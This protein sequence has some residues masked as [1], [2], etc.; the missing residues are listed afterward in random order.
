MTARKPGKREPWRCKY[1]DAE[2]LIKDNCRKAECLEKYEAERQ[3][4]GFA[5]DATPTAIDLMERLQKSLAKSRR[6]Q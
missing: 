3:R 4:L 2:L 1:C 5:T 6:A